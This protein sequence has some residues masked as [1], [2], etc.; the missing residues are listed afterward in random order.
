[1]AME[2]QAVALQVRVRQAEETA[3]A[4]AYKKLSKTHPALAQRVRDHEQAEYR[5][6]IEQEQRERE[7]KRARQKERDSGRG[8]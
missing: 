3:G 4:W 8:R 6:K 5:Q 7:A 2:R 1:M